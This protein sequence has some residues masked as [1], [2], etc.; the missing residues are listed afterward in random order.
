M[1]IAMNRF[2]VKKDRTEDFEN[3]WRNRDSYLHE[4]PGFKEFSLLKGPE[5]EEYNLYSSHTTWESHQHFTDW[6]KSESFRKAHA[7]AGHTADP[8]T[9]GHPQF[10]GFEVIL[11]TP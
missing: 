3:M 6:T 5:T 2:K 1:Y 11:S 7:N 8:V 10:E 9:L 4:N